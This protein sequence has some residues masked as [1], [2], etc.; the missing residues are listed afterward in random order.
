[1]DNSDEEQ[2]PTSFIE[3]LFSFFGFKLSQ[4]RHETGAKL[5]E[6]YGLWLMLPMG[7]ILLLR[8]RKSGQIRR[9]QN[10]GG[11]GPKKK[12][13]TKAQGFYMIEEI[14]SE[15][16]RPRLPHETYASWLNRIS[17]H[18]DDG[19][20]TE[21]FFQVLAQHNQWRFGRPEQREG[22]K[23]K[24]EANLTVLSEKLLALT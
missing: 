10:Q 1:M 3:D 6:T 12:S 20:L 23:R 17:R 5:M 9:I 24:L 7:L 8:L 22:L 19:A 15:K 16:G 11:S 21:E 13:K 4:L 2:I 18:L 14:L